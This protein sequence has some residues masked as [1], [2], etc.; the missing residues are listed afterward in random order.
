MK[1]KP[2][3]TAVAALSVLLVVVSAARGAED[4]ATMDSLLKRIEAL[5]MKNEQ[6]E[7]AS[8]QSLGATEADIEQVVDRM[9][10][11]KEK[12][13]DFNVYWK[14]GLHFDSRDGMFKLQIGGRL[15]LD[16]AWLS[17]DSD[18]RA[19]TNPATGKKI[20]VQS[21]GV[22]ART[23]RL[24]F[25]GTI[26]GNT[27]YK[28]ELDF[29]G[30]E[31]AVQKTVNES[32]TGTK[33]PTRFKSST[34]AFKDVYI[35]FKDLIPVGSLKV[36]HFKEPFSLEELTS[37]R[38]VTFM[39]RSLPVS[40]F[41]PGRNVGAQLGSTALGDRMTWAA[42]MFRETDNR[43][44]AQSEGGGW[45]ATARVTGLPWHEDGGRK[46]AHVGAS[47]SFRNPD[48]T[49]Q[50]KSRPEMH[51]SSTYVDTGAIS[52]S[53][54]MLYGGEAAIVLGAVSLQGEYIYARVNPRGMN[55]LSFQGAYVQASYFL[56]GEN[57]RYKSS[58][59]AF[60]RVRPNQDFGKSSDG[61]KG[62]GAW[63]VA[64]RYSFVD[65]NN[66]S[67]KGGEIEDLT[68]GLNWHLNPNMRVMANYVRAML[69]D[70]GS[71]NKGGNSDLI[72]IRLQV[73][74]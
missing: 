7:R 36:G 65:V 64:A 18:T 13:T 3:V 74:F 53:E 25:A 32:G 56:T 60:N 5:E 40:T 39:E 1:R 35:K 22:E 55:D 24:S 48:S 62:W 57:R 30:T 45:S 21:D 66:K 54:A 26:Y 16:S 73:D 9:V 19:Y 51:L 4:A 20:G 63:E 37:S 59:G 42:G 31:K 2:M 10:K 46:L 12:P 72:G 8:R 34:V 61:S 44:Y 58:S 14:E 33:T 70:N 29:A 28:A 23:L 27:E 71:G 49:V 67:V 68:L 17:E 50:Y 38:Y 11:S 41:S 47:A 15:Y 69:E 52:A 43:G 6:L